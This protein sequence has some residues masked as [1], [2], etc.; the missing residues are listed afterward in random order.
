MGNNNYADTIPFKYAEFDPL[1]FA[2]WHLTSPTA[3]NRTLSLTGYLSPNP[4]QVVK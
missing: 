4:T 1:T 3:E 2:E